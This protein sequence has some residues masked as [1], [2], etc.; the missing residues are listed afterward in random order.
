MEEWKIGRMEACF[1]SSFRR[2]LICEIGAI[3]VIRDSDNIES[4]YEKIIKYQR[5][6]V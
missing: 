3:R 6:N 5:I 1:L 4:P 2:L